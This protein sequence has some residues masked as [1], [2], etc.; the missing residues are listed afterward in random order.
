MLYIEIPYL[1]ESTIHLKD[2]LI[3]AV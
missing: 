1:T 3:D 2:W